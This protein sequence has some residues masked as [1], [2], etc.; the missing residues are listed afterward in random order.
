M[1]FR[2]DRDT[3]LEALVTAGRA[4]TARGGLS[5]GIAG[6]QLTLRANRFEVVGSDPDLVIEAH[7]EVAGEA[8]GSALVPSRL[9]TDI[10]RSFDAGSVAVAAGEEEVRFTCGR[11]EFVVRVAVGAEITRLGTPEVEGIKLPA[12]TFADGLRQVIRAALVDDSRAPQLTGVLMKSTDKGLRLIATDSYRLAFR[13]FEGLSVLDSEGSVLVPAKALGEVQRLVGS[14]KEDKVKEGK[15]GDDGSDIVFRHSDLDAVFDLGGVRITTRLLRGQFPD[16][17]RLVPDS[18][19]HHVNLDREEF[20]SALRRVRLLVRDSKDITTPVRL[21]FKEGTVEL[22]VLTPESGRAVESVESD[23][24]G[25]EAM[26]AFN[27]TY[28]LEGAEAVHADTLMLGINDAGHPALLSAEGEEE[29]RYL[30]MP[31]KVS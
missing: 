15:D 11:A 12:A 1:R 29:F 25:E 20:T 6:L 14:V 5:G 16:V 31:V 28:L 21:T 30:L 8:D 4:A 26:V 3:L 18:F 27:P 23:F 19:T 22:A 17:E 24:R 13:D 7:C 9:V 10:V 2:A